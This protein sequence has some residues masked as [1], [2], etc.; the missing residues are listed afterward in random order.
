MSRRSACLQR[1]CRVSAL[2]VAGPDGPIPPVVSKS[3]GNIFQLNATM[4]GQ[5]EAHMV[6]N[7]QGGQLAIYLTQQEQVG[8][9]AAHRSWLQHSTCCRCGD[10]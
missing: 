7:S 9:C 8:C 3:T 2:S 6:C 10:W 5:E 4:V 1:W